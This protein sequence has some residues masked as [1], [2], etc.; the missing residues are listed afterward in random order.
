MAE[1]TSDS[2]GAK[3]D[4]PRSIDDA[5]RILDEA[6]SKPGMN[7]KEMVTEEYQNLHATISKTASEVGSQL[8]EQVAG[9]SEA[10]TGATG[11]A[12]QKI[13]EM[14]EQGLEAGKDAARKV[15]AKVR[16][17]PWVY[18]GGVALGTFALGLYLGSKS[19]SQD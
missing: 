3:K 9:F 19:K 1:K 5:L 12:S 2:T 8:T 15:D 11:D 13:S 10:F 6:L 18:I 4:R 14:T 7:L 16:E 17:N